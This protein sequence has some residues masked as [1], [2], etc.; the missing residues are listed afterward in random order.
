MTTESYNLHP[1]DLIAI[2]RG[3]YLTMLETVDKTNELGNREKIQYIKVKEEESFRGAVIQVLSISFPMVAVKVVF[4]PKE[5]GWSPT[6]HAVF[7][8][9]LS[10]H[11]YSVVT[12]DYYKSLMQSAYPEG[13]ETSQASPHSPNSVIHHLTPEE[14]IA[15][16]SSEK[17]T[18]PKKSAKKPPR[19]KG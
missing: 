17:P 4:A 1:G 12:P 6:Y 15:E 10:E 5:Q 18:P 3:K 9:N 14:F 8:I 19:R 11:E 2:T 16:F 7:S 13:F